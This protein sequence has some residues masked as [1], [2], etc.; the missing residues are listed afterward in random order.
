MLLS[1]VKVRQSDVN[2]KTLV[3]KLDE[4]DMAIIVGAVAMM[5]VVTSEGDTASTVRST[6]NEILFQLNAQEFDAMAEM[7]KQKKIYEEKRGE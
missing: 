3:L 5:G 6:Y 1:S 2:K 7:Q 4:P